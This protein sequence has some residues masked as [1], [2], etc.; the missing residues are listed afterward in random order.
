M[1]GGL[2]HRFFKDLSLMFCMS[3]WTRCKFFRNL[4]SIGESIKYRVVTFLPAATKLGQGNVF[5]G[6]C[7]S[8]HR[9]GVYASGTPPGR[10][11][12]GQTPPRADP[13]RL[14]TPLGLSTPPATKYA[15]PGLS[16]PPW[17][18][19]TSPR[20]FFFFWHHF[21]PLGSRRPPAY[22]S[23]GGRY[24]S[25]W[26]AFL[27]HMLRGRQLFF[28]ILRKKTVGMGLVSVQILQ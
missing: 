14:S 7:D 23:I 17:T 24:A 21:F 28:F 15:P 9:G 8:V 3:E 19:Y 4:L 2:F 25:Y 18:K 6:V 22:W 27:S 11:P 5:T 1:T 13:P 20:N 12:P 10:H 16:T 26:N